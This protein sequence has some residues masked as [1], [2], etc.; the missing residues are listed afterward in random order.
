MCFIVSLLRRKIICHTV[1]RGKDE[2]M[3]DGQK[4]TS[5]ATWMTLIFS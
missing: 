3:D 2:I 4:E 1:Y 5:D